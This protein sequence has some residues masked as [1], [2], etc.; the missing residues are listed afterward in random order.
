MCLNSTRKQLPDGGAPLKPHRR[1]RDKR[2][3]SS[4]CQ[5]CG[6]NSYPPSLAD[7]TSENLSRASLTLKLHLRESEKTRVYYPKQDICRTRWM[8]PK[9]QDLC[10]SHGISMAGKERNSWG[11]GG[12][13]PEQHPENSRFSA[14]L[15]GVNEGNAHARARVWL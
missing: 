3:G 12:G 2:R 8:H 15:L 11:G 10:L 5:P 9:R 13:S 4:C 7:T 1:P 6:T 14:T